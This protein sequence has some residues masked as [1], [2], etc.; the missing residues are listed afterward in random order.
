MHAHYRILTTNCFGV[1]AEYLP[2]WLAYGDPSLLRL[3]IAC[4]HTLPSA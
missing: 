3:S 1:I 2:H 4:K